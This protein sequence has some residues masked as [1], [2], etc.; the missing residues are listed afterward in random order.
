MNLNREHFIGLVCPECG[1]DG[2]EVPAGDG[3]AIRHEGEGHL[4][5]R[6]GDE[7]VLEAVRLLRVLGE[8]WDPELE[9][10]EMDSPPQ[11]HDVVNEFGAWLQR[12]REA[13][14]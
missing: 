14:Q 8:H 1:L 4:A 7:H 10:F 13:R 3:W 12:D 5:Y 2:I 9:V 6:P 11:F